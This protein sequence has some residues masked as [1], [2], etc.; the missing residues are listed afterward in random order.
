M[1][2]AIP[3][4]REVSPPAL[5][6]LRTDSKP[7]YR[8]FWPWFVISLPAI[9]VAFSIATLVIAVRNADSLVRDDWYDAGV[10]INRDFDREAAA[11]ALGLVA[12]MR[13]DNA[14]VLSLE[15]D[16]RGVGSVD[17]LELQMTCPWSAA[18]DKTIELRRDASGR[19]AAPSGVTDLPGRWDVALAPPGSGDDAW[20]VAGRVE[21]ES[22]T[23]SRL[24]AT[25]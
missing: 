18:R 24:V 15:L 19:F 8:Q 13:L 25:R 10:T 4:P 21:L 7:W 6:R 17:V 2:T 12:V 16:G 14:G 22:G 9:S 11:A 1:S 23:E 20:R 5:G 3:V